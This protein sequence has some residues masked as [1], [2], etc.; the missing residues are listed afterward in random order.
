MVVMIGFTLLNFFFLGIFLEDP[1]RDLVGDGYPGDYNHQ[2]AP[3]PETQFENC[4]EKWIILKI[5]TPSL[6]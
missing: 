5:S 1:R 2:L 6:K 3:A 4:L